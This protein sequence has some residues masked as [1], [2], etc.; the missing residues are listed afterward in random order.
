MRDSMNSKSEA[1]L[2]REFLKLAEHPESGLLS[3]KRMASGTLLISALLLFL[4]L[5]DNLDPL[6]HEWLYLTAAFMAGTSFG[7][8]L[9]FL[10]ARMQTAVMIDH[11]SAES[12]SKRLES[13]EEAD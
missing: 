12:I 9:W 11:L 2:L 3:L 13:L 6:R 4:C 10:H 1:K 8:G 7:M 5:S